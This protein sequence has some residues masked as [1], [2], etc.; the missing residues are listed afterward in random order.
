[1]IQSLETVLSNRLL[2][3]VGRWQEIFCLKVQCTF[4][5]ILVAM[6]SFQDTEK[7]KL[8]KEICGKLIFF[9]QFLFVLH[10]CLFFVTDYSFLVCFEEEKEHCVYFVK[11]NIQKQLVSIE[12]TKL[13]ILLEKKIENYFFSR[14]YNFYQF[15][16]AN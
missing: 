13:I 10:C 6:F 7:F 16:E 11:E 9:A 3:V 8:F 1:M 14:I 12:F 15:L 2:T 4:D 5:K